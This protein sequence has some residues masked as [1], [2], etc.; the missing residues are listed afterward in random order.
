MAEA[1]FSDGLPGARAFAAVPSISHVCDD[2]GGW[3]S[4]RGQ[5]LQNRPPVCI[6]WQEHFDADW[7]VFLDKIG[8]T[9]G[10]ARP[11]LGTLLHANSYDKTPP[12]SEKAQEK[13][14]RWYV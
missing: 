14:K 6:I 9:L 5:F 10:E 7:A 1:P 2:H 4:K 3:F 11:K 13:L 8:C 12:L